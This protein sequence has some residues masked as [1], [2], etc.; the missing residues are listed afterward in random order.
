[1]LLILFEEGCTVVQ[2]TFIA[3]FVNY[4]ANLYQTLHVIFF[5][6]ELNSFL[7]VFACDE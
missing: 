3:L 2:N 6:V 1:M 7:V 4:S 5:L